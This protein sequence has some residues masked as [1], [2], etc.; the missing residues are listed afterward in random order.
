LAAGGDVTAVRVVVIAGNEA[1]TL[2]QD[3]FGASFVAGWGYVY[4]KRALHPLYTWLRAESVSFEP[5]D[6]TKTTGYYYDRVRATITYKGQCL[7]RNSSPEDPTGHITH[8]R[9]GGSEFLTLPGHQYV[10]DSDG[11]KLPADQDIG[12]RLPFVVHTFTWSGVSAPPFPDLD[13]MT[14]KVNASSFAGIPAECLLFETYNS[15]REFDANGD[16]TYQLSYTF[17][18]TFRRNMLS[19]KR[20]GW[21]HYPRPGSGMANFWHRI[22]NPMTTDTGMFTTAD[23]SR[24]FQEDA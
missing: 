22:R 23:F 3:L 12:L 19:D 2:I 21:N 10:Y 8:T 1:A 11:A 4:S 14:G 20:F 13:S 16:K 6:P 5:D 15:Q 17:K 7:N 24:L 9:A 18:E